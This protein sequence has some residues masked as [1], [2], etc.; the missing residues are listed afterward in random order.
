MFGVS[1]FLFVLMSSTPDY[2]RIV[3]QE[4]NGTV[5]RSAVDGGI[6]DGPVDVVLG[7]RLASLEAECNATIVGFVN[8]GFDFQRAPRHGL[9]DSLRAEA[10]AVGANLLVLEAD[11]EAIKRQMFGPR[12]YEAQ[13]AGMPGF[14]LKVLFAAFAKVERGDC[15]E[16]RPDPLRAMSRT[17][18]EL[19]G[20]IAALALGHRDAV[21]DTTN[22]TRSALRSAESLRQGVRECEGRRFAP[23]LSSRP[24][25]EWDADAWRAEVIEGT[26]A[27]LQEAEGAQEVLGQA[28][29]ASAGGPVGEHLARILDLVEEIRTSLRL[30]L[31]D[32]LSQRDLLR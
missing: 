7:G 9:V 30:Y 17:L 10:A 18:A 23:H 26:W 25:G 13:G 6:H 16:V 19:E 32:A 22:S 14:K 4:Y 1:L 12:I 11:M 21:A 5:L 31:E 24:P 15:R 8:Y 3:R 20:E 28:A 29:T 2:A 27:V